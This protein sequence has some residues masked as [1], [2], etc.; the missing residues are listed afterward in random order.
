MARRGFVAVRKWTCP[1]HPDGPPRLPAEGYEREE[2]TLDEAF[3][4]REIRALLRVVSVAGRTVPGSA[5]TVE[6]MFGLCCLGQ[7]WKI[8][9]F[10]ALTRSEITAGIYSEALLRMY[11]V[12]PPR[13]GKSILLEE[14][15]RGFDVEVRPGHPLPI[16]IPLVRDVGEDTTD[17]D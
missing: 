3:D 16:R 15:E 13:F 10:R 6:R 2:L 5:A 12:T 14:I 8:V 11:L 4:A 9:G 7:R 1:H 17:G